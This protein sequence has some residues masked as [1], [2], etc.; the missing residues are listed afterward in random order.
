[1][2]VI[3]ACAIAIPFSFYLMHN[4]LAQYEYKATIS[5]TVFVATGIGA[6]ALTL[7]TVSYQALK[8]ATMDPVKGLRAE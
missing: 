4:W 8:A 5:W 3:I 6:L 1:V 2:L 7:L